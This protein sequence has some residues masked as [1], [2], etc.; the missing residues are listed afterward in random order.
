MSTSNPLPNPLPN[1]KPPAW[2]SRK[3][4][5]VVLVIFVGVIALIY[6]IFGAPKDGQFGL[7]GRYYTNVNWEGE[8]ADVR[9]DPSISFD[10]SQNVPYPGPF[11][12][13][14][15]GNIL[16]TDSGDYVFAIFVDDGA[17]L[18]IDDRLVVDA[19]KGP[20]LQRQAGT[21]NLT[22]GVHKIHVRYFNTVLGGSV[23]LFWTPPGLPEQ[24]VPTN[25]LR[26][27]GKT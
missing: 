3:K 12:A 24:I 21:I 9:T 8:P 23:R 15:T 26:P 27:P 17:L 22:P 5:I 11:S 20:V 4:S 13:D 2:A 1:Q 6:L 14:W 18:E 19:T 16:I 7:L 25:A 10:W